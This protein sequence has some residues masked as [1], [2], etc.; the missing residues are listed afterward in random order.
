MERTEPLTTVVNGCYNCEVTRLDSSEVCPC[1]QVIQQ[2]TDNY[3]LASYFLHWT[4]AEEMMM[5]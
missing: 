5:L 4:L 3:L 1:Q 2:A